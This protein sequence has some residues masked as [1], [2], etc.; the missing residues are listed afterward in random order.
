MRAH[1]SQINVGGLEV[2]VKHCQGKPFIEV[3]DTTFTFINTIFCGKDTLLRYT[4]VIK[5]RGMVILEGLGT[6]DTFLSKP[7]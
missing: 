1:P 6:R 7:L 3:Q 2:E 5:M 4:D